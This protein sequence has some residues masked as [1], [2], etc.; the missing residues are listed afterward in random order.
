MQRLLEGL[1][2]FR[3]GDFEDHRDL[4]KELK[5]EQK[6]HTLFI[7]CSDS[8]VDPNMIT[9]TLPGELFIIRNIANLVPP[10]RQTPEYV[11]TTSAIEYAVLALGVE[12]IIVCGHSN[13]GG[14]AAC[15]RP[16]DFLV[17]MP[18]TR[19]WLELAHPVRDRVLKEIPDSDPEARK[20]MMEQVNVVEQL[21]HLM[22]YPYIRQKI[23]S[24]QLTL[25]GWHYI[26][27]TGEVFIYDKNIGEFLLANG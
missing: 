17:K 14:C 23:S 10:Y 11:A 21:K 9:G 12:N 27:E 5:A 6:P 19:K 16:S 24:R 22:A 4:F 25:S 2:K 1:V 7:T 13:C 20:W 8:R 18:H 3:R 15:L 26:I